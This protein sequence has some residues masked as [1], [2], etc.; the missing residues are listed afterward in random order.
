MSYTIR[1]SKEKK[2]T[3]K[4]PKGYE[5]PVPSKEDVFEVLEKAA[6]PVK[7]SPTSRPKK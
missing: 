6:K 2:V 5:I 7:K 3:Q 4:T 1:M